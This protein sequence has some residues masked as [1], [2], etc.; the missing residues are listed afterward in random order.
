MDLAR[1][2]RDV[3]LAADDLDRSTLAAIDWELHRHVAG[4]T[5]MRE[6]EDESPSALRDA[7]ATWIAW[8]TAA[9]VSHPA[10]LRLRTAHRDTHA[11][12][13]LENDTRVVL[14]EAITKMISAKT[15]GESR[16]YFAALA[17]FAALA[18]PERTLREMRV[19]A[20]HRLGIEDVAERFLHVTTPKLV[21]R[22]R[23]FLVETNDLAREVKKKQTA[24]DLWP[25]DLDTRLARAAT[26]GWPSRLSWRSAAALLPGFE[27]RGVIVRDAPRALGAASFARALRSIGETFQSI[28][29]TQDPFALRVSPLRA[30]ERRTGFVFASAFAE[31]TF[32]ARVLGLSSGRAVDQAR[33]LS[34]AFFLDA[35]FAAMRVALRSGDFEETTALA[36]G[37]PLPSSCKD[38]FPARRDEDLAQ[39]LA[40]LAALALYDGLRARAGDDWFRD[41]RAFA[42]LRDLAQDA[43]EKSLADDQAP[44]KILARRFEEAL[45]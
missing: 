44:E 26:E 24:D 18:E 23:Q 3:A 15:P 27:M 7:L 1:V 34:I 19:E 31:K 35:R 11:T 40:L 17:D 4:L 42:T 39:F 28:A 9:R 14:G 38:V 10:W 21:L 43:P 2:A 41:P 12:V 29:T 6:V 20:F 37:T 8:L 13:R 32:H 16:A 5:V 36:L 45:A 25:L 22:A 33:E 30:S